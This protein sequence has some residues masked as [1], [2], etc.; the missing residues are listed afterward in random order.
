MAA[1]AVLAFNADLNIEALS[2]RVGPDTESIFTDDFFDGLN[3][4]LNALDNLDASMLLYFPSEAVPC[5]CFYI[6]SRPI[7]W[8]C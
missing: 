8:L 6:F 2:E 1:R 3:C 7:T 5:F 4:V